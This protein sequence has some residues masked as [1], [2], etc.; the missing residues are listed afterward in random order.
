MEHICLN[1][2]YFVGY[3]ELNDEEKKEFKDY[4]KMLGIENYT[5]FGYCTIV[6][7]DITI[8]DKNNGKNCKNW[9]MRT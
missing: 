4:C 1:C 2:K 9:E 5:D 6:P 3:G 8:Q 7:E